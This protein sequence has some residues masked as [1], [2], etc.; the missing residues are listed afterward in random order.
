MTWITAAIISPAIMGLVAIID[1]HLISKRM[2]GFRYYLMP[3]GILHLVFGLIILG[4]QPLPE[5]VGTNILLVAF[6]SGFFRATGSFLMLRTMRFEEVSRVIPVS[7]T[8]PIFVAIL[9]VPLLGESLDPIRWLSIFMTVG[10]AVLIS[11]KQNTNGQGIIL[12]KSF[13]VLMVSSLLMGIA[14]ITSKY[15][16]EHISFWNMYSVSAICFATIFLPYSIRPKLLQGLRDMK[17]RN[18]SLALL[19]IN[20]CMVLASI[21]LSFRAI[22]MGPV[23]LV[24]TILSIRPFFVFIFALALSRVFPTVLEERLSRGAAFIKLASIGLIIGG[25]TLLTF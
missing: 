9:A 11:V 8:F 4:L 24:S 21:V 3:V 12:R 23:S 14:N 10:G 20:E 19:V 15:A 1:S 25:V 2:P 18:K 17:K 7:Q 22:E 16:L 6:A 5:G 13:A